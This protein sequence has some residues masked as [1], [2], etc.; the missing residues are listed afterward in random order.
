MGSVQV[1]VGQLDGREAATH[2]IR[3]AYKD[4][5]CEAVLIMDDVSNVSSNI[6]GAAF[7]HNIKVNVS[8]LQNM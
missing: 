7:L 3:G 4:L 5:D 6:N 2:A 1:C 8:Q